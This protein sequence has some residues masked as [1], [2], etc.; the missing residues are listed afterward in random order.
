MFSLGQLDLAGPR[1]FGSNSTAKRKSFIF[2]EQ[3]LPARK[4]YDPDKIL[5]NI[6]KSIGYLLFYL[7][8]GGI[9]FYFVEQPHQVAY[10]TNTKTNL[11]TGVKD[12]VNDI[13]RKTWNNGRV[14][15]GLDFNHTGQ[16]HSH[17]RNKGR[18]NRL[19]KDRPHHGYDLSTRDLTSKRVDQLRE[20]LRNGYILKKI[21]VS[22]KKAKIRK[23]RPIRLKLLEDDLEKIILE[24]THIHASTLD[25]Y[26]KFNCHNP[27]QQIN[28][29]FTQSLFYCFTVITTIGYGSRTPKSDFGKML[30]VVYAIFGFMLLGSFIHVTSYKIKLLLQKRTKI[31]NMTKS[32]YKRLVYVQLATLLYV[33]FPAIVFYYI[34]NVIM[35]QSDWTLTTCFYYVAITLT[36]IGFGDY[37]PTL[38]NTKLPYIIIIIYEIC[39]FI[40]ILAGLVTMKVWLEIMNQ[41]IKIAYKDGKA[42]IKEVA[43]NAVEAASVAKEKVKENVAEQR[44]SLKR[45]FSSASMRRS[46]S[47][48]SIGSAGSCYSLSN[49]DF[50][51]F[52]EFKKCRRASSRRASA[53]SI[54]E[55]VEQLKKQ[56]IM[57]ENL[58]NNVNPFSNKRPHSRSQSRRQ[59]QYALGTMPASSDDEIVVNVPQQTRKSLV[60]QNPFNNKKP[61]SRSQSRRNSV[62]DFNQNDIMQQAVEKVA[63]K[64]KKGKKNKEGKN[65]KGGRRQSIAPGL[66][67]DPVVQPDIMQV[68]EQLGQLTNSSHEDVRKTAATLSIET[69]SL[70]SKNSDKEK[71]SDIDSDNLDTSIITKETN[72]DFKSLSEDE[73]QSFKSLHTDI[74]DNSG[75]NSSV[76]ATPFGL[77][78]AMTKTSLADS[79]GRASKV[80]SRNLSRHS[81]SVG[82]SRDT[83]RRNSNFSDFQKKFNSRR[84]SSDDSSF[85]ILNIENN[86]VCT[87]KT[88]SVESREGC[89][90]GKSSLVD[91]KKIPKPKTTEPRTKKSTSSSDLNSKQK[92]KVLKS[93]SNK[94]L[95]AG[96]TEDKIKEVKD[97]VSKSL[98]ASKETL[99]TNEEDQMNTSTRVKEKNVEL[100]SNSIHVVQ[101]KK[102]SREKKKKQKC[103]KKEKKKEM[104]KEKETTKPSIEAPAST[105]KWMANL[106]QEL[107][108]MPMLQEESESQLGTWSK[109]SKCSSQNSIY[110]GIIRSMTTDT[111]NYDKT[112]SNSSCISSRRV[113]GASSVAPTSAVLSRRNSRGVINPILPAALQQLQNISKRSRRH[114]VFLTG[115]TAGH[116]SSLPIAQPQHQR[117]GRTKKSSRRNSK[118]YNEIKDNIMSRSHSRQGYERYISDPNQTSQSEVSDV[119]LE[120]IEDE[121]ILNAYLDSQRRGRRHSVQHV[122]RNSTSLKHL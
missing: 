100:L 54:S 32:K 8:I 44:N 11:T 7:I 26:Y 82:A 83:S 60:P 78:P 48:A 52:Q 66:F 35:D 57:K 89:L 69:S 81:S 59:S 22:S 101:E 50:E 112:D 96:I 92:M 2:G 115:T 117:F 12:Y 37:V 114:S 21:E 98:R 30:T 29:F 94:S 90:G 70:K 4:F 33:I 93:E 49:N 38:T 111:I 74:S 6:Y 76:Y 61:I 95:G 55:R 104:E 84:V 97:K 80:S 63:K 62:Y 121:I 24:Y 106:Q 17:E 116:T 53:Q 10:C 20:K 36:T 103:E 118:V 79:S 28:W 65:Q 47:R 102:K 120:K 13:F 5:K 3:A 46:M 39:I 16:D 107:A 58:F 23:D 15:D 67:L 113:S 108:L 87:G 85:G 41:S 122:R 99:L 72:T 43:S 40:W 51:N 75:N 109:N 88:S 19:D 86:L 18:L 1:E 91:K 25:Y 14:F 77:T 64:N 34:E 68:L 110:H 105:T 56:L 31:L 71:N 27:D 42:Q 45:T 73:S 119:D 9:A